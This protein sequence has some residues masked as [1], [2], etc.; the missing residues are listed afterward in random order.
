[1]LQDNDAEAMYDPF[2]R[3]WWVGSKQTTHPNWSLSPAITTQC[4]VALPL[5]ADID[6]NADFSD[7]VVS[8]K[9]ACISGR[10]S[11]S[12]NPTR[13][14]DRVP[15]QGHCESPQR[16]QHACQKKGCGKPFSSPKD[17]QRHHDEAHPDESVPVYICRCGYRSPRKDRHH[18]HLKQNSC[19]P[20]YSI[21]LC[22]CS[23]TRHET[24]RDRHIQ[25]VKMCTARNRKN[26]RPP[27]TS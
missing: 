24:C 1:M 25:H 4:D 3:S 7:R 18:R 5:V 6:P 17:L 21:Y 14:T 16:R 27:K 13:P 9:A 8:S 22:V 15:V 23:T 26:G 2:A 11:A 10:L 19:V 20:V 12:G